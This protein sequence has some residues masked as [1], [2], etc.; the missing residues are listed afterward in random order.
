M[1]H[2]R[3]RPMIDDARQR[4]ALWRL[5]LGGVTILAMLI[6]W[7]IGIIAVR[8]LVEGRRFVDT[9]AETLTLGQPTPQQTIYILLIVAGMGF[10]TL[11]AAR[12]WQGRSARSLIGPGAR[13]LRHGAIAAGVTFLVLTV[14][15]LAFL[16]FSEPVARAI[17]VATWLAWLPIAVFALILQTGGE[18]LLFRG[19]LQS[20]LAARFRSPLVAVAVPSLLFGLAHVAPDF[21]LISVATYI[22]I[23]AMFG[24]LAADLTFRTGS[25]GAA[26]GF[27]FA[28][29]AMIILFIAPA[30]DL[31]GLA[32]WQT[33]TD[34]TAQTLASP[35]V[36]LEIAVLVA[37]WFLIRRALRV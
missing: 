10:G 1:I 32:L 29:N 11:I 14:V 6:L 34:P 28:N 13:T 20:Q 2:P 4:P 16:P 31:G 26:W 19:Y 21:P 12:L 5:I 15:T 36:T 27:H 30:G 9:A 22:A 37:I 17:P 23:A 7:T 18:E 33:P 3:Y 8:T 35:L 25:L 24:V